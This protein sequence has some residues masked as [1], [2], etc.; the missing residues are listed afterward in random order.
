MKRSLPITASLVLLAFGAAYAAAPKEKTPPPEAPTLLV[1][2]DRG[3]VREMD[4]QDY[5]TGVLLAELPGSF[6]MEAMKAQAVVS[7]TYALR[8]L[9]S[10][11]HESG[12]D[13]CTNPACCQ[14]YRDPE[15]CPRQ[16]QAVEETEN[17]VLTYGGELIDATFFSCSGGR[18]EA[19]AAVWGTDVAYLQSVTSPGEQAPHNQDTQWL[20]LPDF[21]DR[22][23]LT[24]TGPPSDWFGEVTYTE[25]GGVAE[26]AIGGEVFTGR[27][28]RRL[29]DL[30]STVFT[31]TPAETGITIQTKGFGHRVGMSQYG[32]EAMSQEGAGFREILEHYY[33]GTVVED[34]R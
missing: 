30:R 28:L 26:M 4:L 16:R 10:Q 8:R 25:G 18:T 5:V 2:L 13:V 20:S 19:A 32:A 17:L 9:G 27:D 1:E 6:S 24:L 34:V 14:G 33:P 12:A 7:R 23:G 3:Q 31:I 29:L 11:R 21:T 15:D 22:L